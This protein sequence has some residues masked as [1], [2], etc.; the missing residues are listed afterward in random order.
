[1]A[2][3]DFNAQKMELDELLSTSDFVCCILPASQATDLLIGER[4]LALMK[5]SAIFING[6]RG[7][8][9]DEQALADALKKRIIRAAGLDVYQVEPLP[10][11]SPLMDLN[12]IILFP[13]IG[14][15]RSN[16]PMRNRKYQC[17]TQ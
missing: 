4:E 15:Q 3:T 11:T 14:N 1:L 13:H 16:G 9:V 5:P 2:E 8:I 12:N 10:T 17:G 7:N 6:G